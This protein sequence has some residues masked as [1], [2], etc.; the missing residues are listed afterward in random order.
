[1]INNEVA[2]ITNKIQALDAIRAQLEQDLLKLQEDELELNDERMFFVMPVFP[3]HGLTRKQS[4][5][6][7]NAWN[8][9]GQRSIRRSTRTINYRAPED[10]KVSLQCDH[11]MFRIVPNTFVGPAFLPSEHDDLPHGI[12]F[13]VILDCM[14]GCDWSLT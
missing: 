6:S 5:V 11:P 10:E 14:A 8:W 4:K 7:K 9:S 1:M 13:M 3:I 2:E 12:A